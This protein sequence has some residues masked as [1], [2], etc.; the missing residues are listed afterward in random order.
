MKLAALLLA[1]AIMSA[2]QNGA[3]ARAYRAYQSQESGLTVVHLTD[4]EHAMEV[5][6]VPALGNRAIAM[7]VHG[8]NI[9]YFPESGIPGLLKRPDLNGVP[10]L[11]PWA[12]RLDGPAYWAGDKRYILNPDLHNYI[13]DGFQQ[14]MHGLIQQSSLWEIAAMGSDEKSAYVTGKLPFWKYPELMEQWPFAEEYEMTYRLSGGAL[15]VT[16]TVHNLSKDEIPVSFGFHPYYRIPDKPRDEW[17]VHIPARKKIQT[18]NKLIPTG[19]LVPTDLPDPTPLRD[20]ILDTGYTDLARDGDGDAHFSIESGSEKIEIV[21]GPK[22]PVSVLW[23][24]P[25]RPF[26][27]IEPMTAPTDGLNLAHD[28]KYA[29]LQKVPPGGDWSESFWIK[30]TGF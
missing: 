9:L 13:T 1:G 23:E 8:K 4:S 2:A 30:P 15:Q 5:S 10:F 11:A 14:P 21:F 20:R 16:T 17:T 26:F 28:G 22:Y 18:N 12:N 24:P 7:T 25:R 3:D 29:D 6:I 19:E 27:C